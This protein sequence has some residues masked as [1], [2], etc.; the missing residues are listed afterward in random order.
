MDP[1]T[2]CGSSRKKGLFFSI[3]LSLSF[4]EEKVACRKR[5]V[6]Q[7]NGI[8]HFEQNAHILKKEKSGKAKA[9]GVIVVTKRPP[10]R[11]ME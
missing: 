6:A 8:W 7:P 11:R 3:A 10:K 9:A 5:V 1:Y 2:H 4:V